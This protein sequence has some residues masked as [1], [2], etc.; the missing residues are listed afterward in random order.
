MDPIP[1]RNRKTK[2]TES[3][4]VY[5]GSALRFIYGNDLISKLIGIPLLHTLVKTPLFAALY[6]LWQK[7]P[8]SKKKV[9]PF[10]KKFNVNTSEFLLSPEQY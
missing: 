6:G 4:H 10:I 9:L 3:E 7:S 2:K 5:G 8:F 1:Y